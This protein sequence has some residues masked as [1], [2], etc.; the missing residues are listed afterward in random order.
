MLLDFQLPSKATGPSPLTLS[1]LSPSPQ[2]WGFPALCPPSAPPAAPGGL[3]HRFH[4]Q[5]VG[6]E[7]PGRGEGRRQKPGRKN[8]ETDLNLALGRWEAE[9][10]RE[11]GSQMA[12]LLCATVLPA[13]L[14]STQ[15][16]AR[17]T[18][19][20]RRRALLGPP[21]EAD[22][23]RKGTWGWESHCPHAST[24]YSTGCHPAAAP[25][26]SGS[27]IHLPTGTLHTHPI[28]AVGHAGLWD[29]VAPPELSGLAVIHGQCPQHWW[30]WAPGTQRLGQWKWLSTTGVAGRAGS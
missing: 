26:A 5:D 2:G 1:C 20:V 7:D 23:H 19:E 27:P 30:S 18:R 24:R 29:W 9:P 6:P 14:A 28:S 21:A 11:H 16:F 12:L 3:P 13:P 17:V 22:R 10:G 25:P 15:S 4:S 8:V